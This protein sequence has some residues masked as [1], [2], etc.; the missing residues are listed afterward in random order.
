[1]THIYY[2]WLL[3]M[4]TLIVNFVA[5]LFTSVKDLISSVVYIP[6]I[7]GASFMLWYRPIYNGFMKEHALFYYMY[8]I[9]AGFHLAFSVYAVIGIPETGCAGIINCIESFGA[10]KIVAGA[11]SVPATVGWAV[12]GLGNLWYYKQI[13]KHNHEREWAKSVAKEILYLITD[14]RICSRHTEGHSFAQ[15]RAELASHGA[16]AYFTR[17]SNV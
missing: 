3:L 17:G 7:G 16:K 15:A 11:L 2:L 13:W 8:F 5:C 10:H 14:A 6:V 12:Q 4:L 9:F 1:M